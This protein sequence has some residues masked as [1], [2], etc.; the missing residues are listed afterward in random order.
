MARQPTMPKAVSSL[1]SAEMSYI[2]DNEE[3]KDS[4]NREERKGFRVQR[5]ERIPAK[6]SKQCSAEELRLQS[7]LR[8]LVSD[9]RGCQKSCSCCTEL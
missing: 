8:E 1:Q 3:S 4:E 2:S 6:K 5:R 9:A 7:D